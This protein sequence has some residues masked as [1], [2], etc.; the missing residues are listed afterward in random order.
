MT[1]FSSGAPSWHDRDD[2]HE[3]LAVLGNRWTRRRLGCLR[4]SGYWK[5]VFRAH[6]QSQICETSKLAAAREGIQRFFY[7][8]MHSFL[9][10]LPLSFASRNSRQAD[11]SSYRFPDGTTTVKTKGDLN[12]CPGSLLD[13]WDVRKGTGVYLAHLVVR[14]LMVRISRL[15]E[16]PMVS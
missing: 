4:C 16:G 8:A 13:G 2:C 14:V 1:H 10:L 3:T 15:G 6:T 5:Q 7:F 11:P 9:G 12:V